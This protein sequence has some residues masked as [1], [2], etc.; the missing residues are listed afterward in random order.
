MSVL[1][2]PR[3]WGRAGLA[4]LALAF[5]ATAQTDWGRA[6]HVVVPQSRAFSLDAQNGQIQLTSVQAQVRLLDRTARTTLDIAVHNPGGRPAEAILLLP[7]PERAVVSGFLFEGAASE[8][9][10]RLLPADEARRT[11]DSIVAKVRDPA[12]LEFAGYALIRSS[13]F[14]V[15]PGGNQRVRIIYEHLLGGEG[16]RVDYRLPRSESLRARVPW[17]IDVDLTSTAPI[18]SL[19]SPSHPLET[20]ELSAKRRRV[21][22]PR[23]AQTDPGAFL[24]SWVAGEGVGASMFAYPDPSQGGGYFLLMAGLP[25]PTGQEVRAIRREITLVIDRSGSMAGGKL[26]QSLAAALQVVEGLEDGETFNILDY[27]N[28]VAAF[29]PRPVLRN[30][31]S[32]ASARVYLK[33][34]RP[35]GGTNIHDAM[36]E[37]L[38]QPPSEGRL[39]LVFFLTDGLPT[40]GQTSEVVIRELAEKSNPFHRRIF[41]FGVGDDVNAPLLDHIADGSK[42]KST[43]VLPSE[44]VEV[45]V[46]QLYRQLYGPVFADIQLETLDEQG[47]LTTRVVR[48]PMPTTLPDLFEG[49]QIVLLGRYLGE[50]PIRF[51]LAGNFRGEARRFRFDFDLESATT[52]NAFVPRLWAGRRIAEMVNEVRQAGANGL[53]VTA[54]PKTKELTDEIVR[55][56]TRF[57]IL[58]EYTAFLATEGTDLGSWDTLVTACELNLNDR[59]IN[60]RSGRGAVVQSFNNVQQREQSWLNYSN[61]YLAD[62]LESVQHTGIQQVCDRAFLRRGNQW[63]DSRLVADQASLEPAEVIDFGSPE[64][65]Q[66]IEV[67]AAQGRQAVL[68]LQGEVLIQ[69]E[70]RNILLRNHR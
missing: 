7:V 24:L 38:R 52:R 5:T 1:P 53:A 68:S 48:D 8:P 66:L 4:V 41:T 63:I 54:N 39:P 46:A 45:K 70:G 47:E 9:T 43:Y 20:V 10:A 16:A 21:R 30:E 60:T 23:S 31:R 2:S 11:Y 6:S 40:I 3:T 55:L 12:L 51:R 64:H 19:Y 29:S 32:I 58:S 33:A 57:G 69:H 35:G 59:A 44:D 26:E 13:V 42:A 17:E 25:Q 62:N 37:A 18:A 49:D 50:G 15:A 65:R 22:L 14:P 36:L 67:M 56:S 28:E 27:S 34:L 61:R